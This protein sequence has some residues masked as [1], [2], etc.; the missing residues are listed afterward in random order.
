VLVAEIILKQQLWFI[1]IVTMCSGI[2]AL[3]IAPS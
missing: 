3:L 2:F 1:G